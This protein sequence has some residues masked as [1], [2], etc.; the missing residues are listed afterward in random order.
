MTR[1]GLFAGCL[2][3]VFLVCP[4]RG[5]EPE[6]ERPGLQHF[7]RGFS[8]LQQNRLDEAIAEYRKALALEPTLGAAHAELALVLA[9]KGEW[10]EV[11][12]SLEKAFQFEPGNPGVFVTAG[13]VHNLKGEEDKAIEDY[14]RALELEPRQPDAHLNL[15][16]IYLRRGQVAVALTHFD[17]LLRQDPENSLAQLGSCLAYARAG[18]LDTAGRQCE[19]ARQLDAS[20]TERLKAQALNSYQRGDLGEAL[21]QA[22]AATLADPS[23]ADAWDRFGALLGESKRWEEAG[24]KHRRALSLDANFARAHNNLGYALRH[25]GKLDEAIGEYERAVRL[26]ADYSLAYHNLGEALLEKKDYGRAREAFERALELDPEYEE[27]KED[28]AKTHAEWGLVLLADEHSVEAEEHFTAAL[29]SAEVVN[30]YVGLCWLRL[31]SHSLSEAKSASNKAIELDANDAEGHECRAAVS[32][33]EGEFQRAVGGWEKAVSLAQQNANHWMGLALAYLAAGRRGEAFEA[34]RTAA[35]L[36]PFYA[37]KAA[38]T[39]RGRILWSK[40][41]LKPALEL[42]HLAQN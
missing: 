35:R 23:D 12:A 36:A 41:L 40:E 13:V 17:A 25:L 5:Q 29:E 24:D 14:E 37:D 2:V 9:L 3:F 10:T 32:Y 38:M 34:Y 22:Q 7:H 42:V 33:E 8:L 18:V 21:V 39:K 6:S 4:V 15:G 30:A 26:K 1:R 16:N 11:E 28:L 19:R 31:G 27:V 20:V